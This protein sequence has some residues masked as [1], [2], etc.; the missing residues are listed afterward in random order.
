[1]RRR[2]AVMLLGGL[3]AGCQDSV[4][5]SRPEGGLDQI[6][7]AYLCG[8]RFEL[9]NPDSADKLV[10]YAVL[11]TAETGDFFLPAGTST[12][13]SLTR[14]TAVSRGPLQ[15]SSSD[16]STEPVENGATACPSPALQQPQSESGEWSPPF[17]W[18]V[19]AVHLHLLPSGRVLSWGRIGAPQLYNP[20]DESFIEVPSAT[21]VFCS[22]HTFLADGRLLVSGGH[23]NDRRGLRDANFFDP[24]SQS[25]L[26]VSAMSFARWYPTT[27]ALADG[28]VITLAGT[29]QSAEQVEIPEIWSGGSWRQLAGAA[30]ALPYYPRT[31]VAPNGV[32]F[33]AGELQQSAFLNPA[34]SGRWTSGPSSNYGR[35]DYGSAVMYQPGKVMILGGSDPPDGAPTNTAELIDLNQAQPGWRYTESMKYPRR[36]FN[37]TLLPDG[38]V[39]ATGGTSAPGFSDPAGAVHAAELWSPVTEQWRVLASNRTTRVYHSTTLLL[40]DGRVLHAG[41]GDG[42]GLPRELNAEI[43]SP[44]YLFWGPRPL[45]QAAPGEAGLGE[46]FLVNSPDVL[47]VVRVTLVRLG[48]VTHAF[49]QSQRFVELSFRRVAEGLSVQAPVNGA[50]APP[51]PYLLTLLDDAGVPSTS[52][53]IL[54]H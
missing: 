30:R 23:L 3:T 33:Y 32:L 41:S 6:T 25:W 4:K 37:A 48:S 35:R 39:L 40:P 53:I 13:P 20:A 9:R 12:A 15:I 31:F 45:L 7:V 10:H 44:P 43:F 17:P 18:P 47:K 52:A 16:G 2:L 36:Q 42:P 49:D 51:G 38:Q 8:N 22:G 50:M 5:P 24:G 14:L 26:P 28:Q 29:D 19:V 54:I 34:G 21:M 1:M 27:T 11:G 46:T